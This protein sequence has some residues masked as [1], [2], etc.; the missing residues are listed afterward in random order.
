MLFRSLVRRGIDLGVPPILAG[1]SARVLYETVGLMLAAVIIQSVTRIWFLRQ[2]GRVGQEVLLEIRRRLF[3]HFQK[4]DV[5]FHDRYTSGRVVSR[6]TNDIDAIMELLAGGFDGLIT[7]VLTLVGVAVLLLVLDLKLGLVCL[8]CFPVLLLLVR[9]FSKAS[10]TT[11]RAVRENS[12]LV[13]VQFVETLTGI[14]AVEAYRRERR[15]QEIFEDLSDRYRDANVKSFRLVAIF[16]PGIKM[17]GNI[18]IGVVLLYG[19]YL[20]IQGEMTIGVLAA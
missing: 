20:V 8:I 10:S 3:T 15:N 14:R 5:R 13:I 17:I 11:Y 19:G 9:W 16:M 7:A 4:L 1:G 18:T 12:A 2:S 6:L